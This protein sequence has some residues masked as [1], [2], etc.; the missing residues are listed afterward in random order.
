MMNMESSEKKWEMDRDFSEQQ[1][2][3]VCLCD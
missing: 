3:S 2:C 1:E